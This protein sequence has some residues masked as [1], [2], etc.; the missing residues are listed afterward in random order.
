MRFYEDLSKISKNREAQRSYY[1]PYDSL[2]KALKGDRAE[3]AFYNCLNG[4]W[5]FKFY[6]RDIDVPEKID[7]WDTI[8][9]PSCW[10]LHGYERPIY[11]NV[12]YPYPVDPPYVPDENPCGVYMKKFDIDADWGKRQAYIVF[13]GVSPCVELY[14]NGEFVGYSQVSHMQ[15]EFDIT[16]FVKEGENELVAKVYKWCSG[17]Y[18]EDQDFFRFNGIFRD[19]YLLSRESEHIKDIDITAD[20]KNICVSCPD[21]EIYDMDGNIADLENPVLWNAE[22][23]YLYTVVVKG[24]TEFIPIKV[25]MREVSVSDKY[26]LLIN[27]TPVKLKGVNHHDT[28]AHKG[29]T[30][31]DADLRLDLEKMK[32]LNINTIRMSHYPPTPEF[33]N[34]CDE[35]GFY[36][37]DEADLEMHGFAMRNT[38]CVWDDPE[39]PDEWIHN[40]PEWEDSFIERA[41]R[42]VERD[43]NHPSVIIWSTGNES[44]HGLNHRKMIDWIK[45]RDNS[46]L[47]HCEDAS[48]KNHFDVVDIF[49][50]MYVSVPDLEEKF[51]NNPVLRH[52]VFL[53]E[54]AHAMGN[55]PGDVHDYVELMY[56]H[57]K[58]IGGCIWEWADHTVIENG[59]PKYGGD[60][61][62]ITNDKNFCCDGL[63]FYDRSFKAGSLNTKYSYQN[64]ASEYKDGK[65]FITN[66]YDFT[67]LNAYDFKIELTADG[68]VVREATVKVDAEPASTVEVAVPFE[69]DA[70]SKLGTYLNIYQLDNGYERGFVQ[71]EISASAAEVELGKPAALTEDCKEIKVVAGNVTYTLSK[72]YGSI[73]SIKKDGSEL[74]AEPMKLTL[75][76]APIDNERLLKNVWGLFDNTWS[77]I[78]V[79]KAFN[80]V[81]SCSVDG[82]CVVVNGSIAG[83][84]RAPIIYYTTTYSFYDNGVVKVDVKGEPSTRIKC[85]FLPRIGYEFTLNK[86]NDSF[87]YFGMGDGENYC[88]MCYHAKMGKY[89]SSAS[90][91]YVPY[92]M[93][94]EHGNHINT[95]YLK[96]DCGVE[97]VAATKFEFNVSEYTS[98]ALTKATHIDE[99][100]KN[101]K[102]NV[103]IDYKTS[104]IGSHSCGPDLMEQYRVKHE[105]FEYSFYIK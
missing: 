3:S 22:N 75:W 29:Y 49:S 21:Y 99:L 76:H 53:C 97:F 42:M 34:M 24:K 31:S 30:M 101:G 11:T 10:Q 62:E 88:D 59:V 15:A 103:R 46:R 9:V 5:N 87:E 52:P 78:N 13:E 55:G 33:L 69:V 43:K 79:N 91:E 2:E 28:D 64:F 40:L 58:F 16:P 6:E 61:G 82:N 86:P 94:Q 35:M 41:S 72:L 1:I 7:S 8:P 96:M 57:P 25:G 47:I 70:E 44:G 92:I 81:Y 90:G 104:G 67:N 17:S 27:G 63:V 18:L 102:T 66:R 89:R 98:D 54:Y 26:E 45:N 36:V 19:V 32:E 60:F 71:H 37:I 95:K 4:D 14:V 38:G 105:P 65:L 56:K 77:G 100:V 68:E 39:R 74:L 80:K 84:G 83:V 20:C 23:P 48:R 85:E 93:P 73:A 51:I 12:L 50:R